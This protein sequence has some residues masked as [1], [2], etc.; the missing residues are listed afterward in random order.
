MGGCGWGRVKTPAS[1][2]NWHLGVTDCLGPAGLFKIDRRTPPIIPAHAFGFFQLASVALGGAALLNAQ[3]GLPGETPLE[4]G[5]FSQRDAVWGLFIQRLR[6]GGRAPLVAQGQ[7]QEGAGD[8]PLA[9][10]DRVADFDLARSFDRLT[11]HFDPALA[12]FIGGQRPRLVKARRPKPFVDSDF[13]HKSPFWAEIAG[14]WLFLYPVLLEKG[15]LGRLPMVIIPRLCQVKPQL[16]NEL[17]KIAR[18][19]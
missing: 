11:V 8:D 1:P 12:D 4:A 10:A 18:S 7:N 16:G 6:N 19:S 13:V 5:F 9:G 14:R 2:S 15:G 3:G 17:A